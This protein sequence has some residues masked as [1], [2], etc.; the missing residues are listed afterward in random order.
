MLQE[1]TLEG[2]VMR[3]FISSLFIF[4]LAVPS[5]ADTNNANGTTS[6]PYFKTGQEL[7]YRIDA[8][9]HQIV[10]GSFL[11]N[12]IG[13]EKYESHATLVIKVLKSDAQSSTLLWTYDRLAVEFESPV[14][15]R[16]FDSDQSLEEDKNGNKYSK[17]FAQ[18]V[19]PVVGS[20]ITVQLDADHQVVSVSGNSKLMPT[21]DP[22]HAGWLMPLIG[23]DGIKNIASTLFVLG[24]D[25][26][27]ASNG[28]QWSKLIRFDAPMIGEMET[29]IVHKLL[30]KTDE[31][32]MI[33]TSSTLAPKSAAKVGAYSLSIDHQQNFGLLRWDLKKDKIR[34]FE[35]HSVIASSLL[36]GA[37]QFMLTFVQRI[38]TAD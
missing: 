7:R 28:D 8:S 12:G 4:A 32:A 14:D 38:A 18:V 16:R 9:G 11:P 31:E 17:A 25:V 27:A 21:A 33:A 35:T 13:E 2:I 5:I 1:L 24:T 22:L 20:P 26:N 37:G 23:T 6:R 15:P 30:A 36:S 3:K 29:T 34:S 10:L 19:R